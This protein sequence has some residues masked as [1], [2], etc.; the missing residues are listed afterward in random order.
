[1]RIL[2]IDPG[3]L[4]SARVVIDTLPIAGGTFP[5]RIMSYVKAT[6]HDVL[7]DVRIRTQGSNVIVIE[8][9]THYGMPVGAE[10][11]DTVFWTGR[12][13]Q[14]SITRAVMIPRR[15]V[16][17]HICNSQRVKDNNIRAALIERFGE[18]GTKKNPGML[19][20]IHGD[21]WQALAL[22]ITF[23]EN[24]GKYLP[25]TVKA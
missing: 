9:I 14:A 4:L 22:A 19:Y 3:P 20:G 10:V 1:M 11:F 6:N 15:D 25:S 8:K 17:L 23:A 21:C 16:K 12:F 2:A 7:D 13:Y 18:P 5:F 24:A